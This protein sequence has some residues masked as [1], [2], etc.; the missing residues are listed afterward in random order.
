MNDLLEYNKKC[1]E[2]YIHAIVDAGFAHKKVIG[3]ISHLLNV[4]YMWVAKVLGEPY[5]KDL[6]TPLSMDD[7]FK[8]NNLVHA[9]TMEVLENKSLTDI[10]KID[11]SGTV[12][13]KRISTVLNEIILFSTEQRAK[14]GTQL[15]KFHIKVPS[16]RFIDYTKLDLVEEF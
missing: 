5:N 3:E 6:Y 2:K 11:V 13:N 14:I 15:N 4:H 1:N 8:A 10:I 16:T 9:K 7:L 12:L